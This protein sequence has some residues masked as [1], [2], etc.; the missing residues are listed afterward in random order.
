MG[1]KLSGRKSLYLALIASAGFA[2]NQAIFS[3]AREY[4]FDLGGMDLNASNAYRPRFCLRGN[5]PQISN[6]FFRDG[7]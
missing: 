5:I 7:D 4:Q 3:T 2:S 6:L 1:R